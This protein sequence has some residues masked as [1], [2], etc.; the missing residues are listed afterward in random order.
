MLFL[1]AEAERRHV[2]HA[3]SRY[4]A[5]SIVAQL[6]E[7]PERLK[8]G[9]ESRELTIMFS[10][11]RGFTTI[12]EALDPQGLTTFLNR[13]LTPMTDV[14]LSNS[15]TVDKYM[16]DGI[17]AFWNAP[18]ADPTHAEHACQLNIMPPYLT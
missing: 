4:L 14:I 3:F 5:P 11:I 1:R 8:L 16:A 12:S 9:G 18:L 2:R 10:D 7:H 13:Y 6:A 15:G 17:M